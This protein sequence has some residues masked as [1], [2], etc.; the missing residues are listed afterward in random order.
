LIYLDTHVV[1]WLYAGKIKKLSA[2]AKDLINDQVNLKFC[3]Q[4]HRSF[5]RLNVRLSQKLTRISHEKKI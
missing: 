1:V 5:Q 3:V 2:Q 4:V